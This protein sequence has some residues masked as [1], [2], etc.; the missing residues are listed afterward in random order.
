MTRPMIAVLSLGLAATLAASALAQTA[1]VP[2]KRSAAPLGLPRTPEI[3]QRA[4]VEA[5]GAL[6]RGLDKVTGQTRDLPM[7]VGETLQFG[8]LN[9]LLGQ[10]RQPKDDP[11]SD[12]FAELSITDRE[13]GKSAFAGWMVASSP[14]LSAL[15]DARYDVWVVSCNDGSKSAT[16]PDIR[17]VP[18]PDAPVAGGEG[19]ALP[20]VQGEVPGADTGDDP[21]LPLP[22]PPAN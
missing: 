9:V 2:P 1:P 21:V 18:E 5:R 13:S 7:A 3:E 19:E 8:R 22:V 15:D 16:G 4:V 20:P 6:L 17:Y 10:C 12:A 14:A 11:E